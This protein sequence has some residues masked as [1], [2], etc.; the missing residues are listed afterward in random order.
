VNRINWG[1]TYLS[2]PGLLEGTRRG[3]GRITQRGK[4]FLKR[5][6]G[7]ISAVDLEEFAEYRLFKSA[8]KPTNQK[9]VGDL[10][11]TASLQSPE[12]QLDALYTELNASLASDLS[13]LTSFSLGRMVPSTVPD[14]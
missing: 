12:E 8:S 2:K 5:K 10:S 1:V 4:E 14:G 13:Q 6:N 11:P 3:H 7:K 9:D